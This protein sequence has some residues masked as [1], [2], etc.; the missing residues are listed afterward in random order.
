ML[1]QLTITN[2]TET[3]FNT[4]L[5]I[6]RVGA[7]ILM[8]HHGYDK[9]THFTGYQAVFIN[10]LGLGTWLSLALVVFAEFFC[11]ILLIIGLFTSLSTIPPLITMAVAVFIAHGGAVFAKGE[12]ATLYLFVYAAIMIIGPGA[13]SLDAVIFKSLQQKITVKG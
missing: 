5:L 6:L 11:S 4:A 8:M 1:Q 9:L 13:Y 2:Y 10:F 7:G 3:R 12:L